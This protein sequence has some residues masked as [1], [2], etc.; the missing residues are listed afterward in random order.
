MGLK[1]VKKDVKL[2][3]CGCQWINKSF[4]PSIPSPPR[5][6]PVW[7]IKS[8]FWNVFIFEKEN[9]KKYIT[10]FGIFLLPVMVLGSKNLIGVCH[11]FQ[12]NRLN[13]FRQALFNKVKKSL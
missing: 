11:L 7:K 3:F 2:K 4:G 10:L 6:Y 9:P 12:A 1:G 8:K 13:F 5:F